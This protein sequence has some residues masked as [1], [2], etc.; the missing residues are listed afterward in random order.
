VIISDGE[1]SI[2]CDPWFTDTAYFGSW[3]HYPPITFKPSEFNF[4][5]YIYISHIH[6]DHF[7]IQTLEQIDHQIPILILERKNKFLKTA[8]QKIGFKVIEVPHNQKV[9]LNSNITVEILHAGFCDP[10]LCGKLTACDVMVRGEIIDSMAVFSNGKQT[11]VNTNDCP[12]YIAASSAKIIKKQYGDIDCLLVGY[13]SAG[14]YP[15]CFD[16]LTTEKKKMKARHK[17]NDF[18]TMMIR[19]LDIFKPTYWIPFAG[20]YTLSGKLSHLNDLRGVPELEYLDYTFKEPSIYHDGLR[21]M[22]T[23]CTLD[24]DTGK[25]DILFTPDDQVEKKRY[26]KDVLNKR[27]FDYE[28]DPEVTELE[29]DKLMIGAYSRFEQKRR[30]LQYTSERIIYFKNDHDYN[31]I[32]L[33]GQGWGIQISKPE[34]NYLIIELDSKL[35][36]RLLKGPKYAHWNNAEVGSHLKFHRNPDTY[37]RALHHC[38]YSLYI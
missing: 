25:Q 5:D 34:D 29:I 28:N 38:L 13:A 3:C 15:Q 19:Y 22:N 4:V 7:D 12:Y 32:T 16:N 33:N 6:P 14:P 21:L 17:K 26:I 27:I 31:F 18:I 11:V 30:E 35:L 20:R 24:L 23:G 8:I 1:T 36:A 2:L 9:Y 10:E 37:E